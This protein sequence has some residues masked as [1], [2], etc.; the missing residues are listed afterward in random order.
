M[1]GSGSLAISATLY[2]KLP[3]DP[4]KDFA[5]IVLVAFIPFVLV[6][7]PSLPVQSVPELVTY[8]LGRNPKSFRMRPHMRQSQSRSLLPGGSRPRRAFRCAR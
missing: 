7:H 2:K 4:A 8:V 3:Y 6:V 1:A 5:P